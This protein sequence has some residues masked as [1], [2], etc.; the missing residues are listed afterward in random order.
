MIFHC[1]FGSSRIPFFHLLCDAPVLR[2]DAFFVVIFPYD[3]VEEFEKNVD[4]G[5][6]KNTQQWIIGG[7]RQCPV[8]ALI[9]ALEFLLYTK[10][11]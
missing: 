1:L 10:K 7:S 11:Y 6:L 2:K 5:R 3:V 8:E 9:I 4:E